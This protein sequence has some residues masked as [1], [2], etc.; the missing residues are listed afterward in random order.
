MGRDPNYTGTGSNAAPA[1][2][3]SNS[4]GGNSLDDLEK[5][6]E[7][8]KKGILTEEEFQAKKRQILG[9]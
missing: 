5:L 9:L 8:R 4:S 2:S 1:K 6:A 7:L 3:T